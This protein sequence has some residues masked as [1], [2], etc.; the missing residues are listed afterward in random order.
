MNEY[1]IS[2]AESS[3]LSEIKRIETECG[4]SAWS[5]G[6]YTAEQKHPDAIM[7]KAYIEDGT[8]VGF[9]AGRVPAGGEGEILNI[10]TA[11]RFQR[12]GVGSL[13][14]EEFRSISAR[15]RVSAIWLE[16]R[17]GNAAAIKF[18]E[19]HGFVKKGFRPAY[20]SDPTEN[21]DL[22]ALALI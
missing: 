1:K 5:I 10:G 15:R 12:R 19:S 6:A 21:A 20:Y 11:V 3:D 17:S 2:K 7:L 13:L 18:Y 9:L 4:L 8:I 14:I 22:M 16:V